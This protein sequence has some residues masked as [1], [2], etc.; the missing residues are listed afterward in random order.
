M[1]GTTNPKKNLVDFTFIVYKANIVGYKLKTV[2]MYTARVCVRVCV[3]IVSE[4]E[5]ANRG[6]R[7]CNVI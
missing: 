2:H 7:P 4:L 1:H 3:C 6:S 5:K